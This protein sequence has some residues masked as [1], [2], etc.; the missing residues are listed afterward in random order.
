MRHRQRRGTIYLIT[1]GT[2]LIVSVLAIAALLSVR[3]Q[4]REVNDVADTARAQLYAQAAIDMALLRIADTPDWR[5]KLAGGAWE[6]D[7]PIGQGSYTIQATDPV[8]GRLDNGMYDPVEIVATGRSG[9][10]R[11]ML[12][13]R[14]NVKQP[15][16]ACLEASLHSGGNLLLDAVTVNGN[17]FLSSNSIVRA[18]NAAQIHA[19]VQAS[20]QIQALTGSVYHGSTTTDGDWPRE[21]PAVATVLT[22]YTDE[23]TDIDI[24]DLPLW[25]REMLVN[26]AMKTDTTAWEPFGNCSLTWD[27][28]GS[29]GAGCVLVE[30]RSA[31]SDGPSQ[32]AT[33]IIQSG[34]TYYTK[35][36]A[37]AL[38]DLVTLNLRITLTTESTGSGTQTVS[39]PWTEVGSSEFALV[40]G[41]LTPSWTGT[42]IKAQWIVESQTA[43]TGFK[44]DDALLKIADAEP[45]WY[46]IHRTVLSPASNP[47][48]AGETNPQGIYVVDCANQKISIRDCR[49]VGTLLLLNCAAGSHIHGSVSWRPAVVS[50]DPNVTNLPA[51]ITNKALT[52][53]FGSAPLDEGTVNVNFNPAGTPMETSEDDDKAD[54]Y[55]SKI[56]GVLYSTVSFTLANHPTI[57]GALVGQSGVTVNATN[58]DVTY[59]PVY[60]EDNAPP[61]FRVDPVAEIVPGSFRQVVD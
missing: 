9:P 10:A 18:S 61:G 56:E 31:E 43:T 39:T 40:E 29:S 11:H 45:D 59:D 46:L 2:A 53:D 6:A 51:L 16:L 49:I 8:D 21:M 60:C 1:M 42:L 19:D 32:D 26:T 12:S 30:N 38:V 25:D 24:E 17:Q 22:Y 44:I 13:V 37:K 47:F 57:H 20:A 35:V 55:A 14:L 7:Q 15:G 4:R 33:D 41:N 34:E 50:A 23:G 3:V 5:E 48:G 54:T 28:D 27:S 36:D 58:L 52:I